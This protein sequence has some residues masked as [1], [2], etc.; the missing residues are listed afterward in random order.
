MKEGERRERVS[1]ER[2]E[3]EEERDAPLS[4]STPY[5]TSRL[6]RTGERSLPCCCRAQVAAE[7]ANGELPP[8][9]DEKAAVESRRGLVRPEDGCSPSRDKG[10]VER[11]SMMR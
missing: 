10:E 4:G 11:A 8:A 6:R 7:A 9:S 5:G 2:R 1:D 3:G